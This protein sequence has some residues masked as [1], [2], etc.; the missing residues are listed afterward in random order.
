MVVRWDTEA[1]DTLRKFDIPRSPVLSMNELAEDAPLRAS[2]SIVEVPH[3]ERGRYLTIG[4]PHFETRM[5]AKH[6]H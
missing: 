3:K 4:S 2:G 1:V 6:S 5:R